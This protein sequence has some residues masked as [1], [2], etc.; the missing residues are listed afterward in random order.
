VTLGHSLPRVPGAGGSYA[1]AHTELFRT[2]VLQRIV[3]ADVASLYPSIMLAFDIKPRTDQLGVFLGLLR[4]LTGLRLE[5]KAAARRLPPSDPARA[6]HDAVQA[7]MKVLINSFYGSLG[8]SFALFG[9]LEAAAKVTEQGRAILRL[10]LK[11][12]EQRG[13]TLIEADTDGV[14]FSVPEGWTHEDELRLIEEVAAAL[15]TGIQVEHDGR[16][17]RMYSH[18][19]KNYVLRDYEGRIRFVGVAFR[20]SRTEPYG[21]RF[22]M[23]AMPYILA[24]DLEGLRGLYV[25]L[26]ERL[27]GRRVEV[28][29]LCVSMP[30]TKTPERY[31]AAK[32]REEAYEVLLG[33]G[34]TTWRTGER[35]RYYQAV[36]GKKKLAE[37]YADDYD[38]ESYVK[39][40]RKTYAQRLANAL[41]EDTLKA[42]FADP[43]DSTATDLQP[44]LFDASA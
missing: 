13:V 9:D 17:E 19:A 4:E 23:D 14:L 34:R 10:M 29:E 3:K 20:S 36:G 33:S 18:A 42:I 8:T 26:V 40:L 27:R 28:R 41:G 12:L 43:K 7:A 24:E 30:L 39:K 22:L 5:H 16:Y 15:P 37:Q 11:E 35:V 1:G 38:P 32:R 31:R 21:E 44:T 6:H 2:G 25:D